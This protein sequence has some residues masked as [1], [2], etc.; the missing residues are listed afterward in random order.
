[1]NRYDWFEYT[2]RCPE[3]MNGWDSHVE[4]VKEKKFS[5]FGCPSGGQ[6][7]VGIVEKEASQ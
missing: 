2:F 1:M 3:C 5:V 7:E 4:L 6:V